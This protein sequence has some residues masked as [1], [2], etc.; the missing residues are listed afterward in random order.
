[1]FKLIMTMRRRKGMSPEEF[2]EYYEERHVK[3]LYSC[4]PEVALYRRNYIIVNDPFLAG[5][6]DGRGVTEEPEF[7]VFTEAG[8]DDREAAL[9]AMQALLDGPHAERIRED[10]DRFVERGSVKFYVV[11]SHESPKPWPQAAAATATPNR[12]GA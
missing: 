3:L 1:M 10:E 7:D 11:E 2:R 4:V 8:Y 5:G 9:E 12:G 6:Q